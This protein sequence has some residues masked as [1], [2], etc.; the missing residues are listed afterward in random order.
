M[1]RARAR[2]RRGQAP[3][4]ASICGSARWVSI[5]HPLAVGAVSCHRHDTDPTKEALGTAIATTA[6]AAHAA[7]AEFHVFIGSEVDAGGNKN[8]NG[9]GLDIN[10]HDDVLDN[11]NLQEHNQRLSG[12]SGRGCCRSRRAARC[13]TLV[14]Q[15]LYFLLRATNTPH[16]ASRFT[17]HPSHNAFRGCLQ[18]PILKTKTN[19]LRRKSLLSHYVH[20]L[21][22]GRTIAELAIDAACSPSHAFLACLPEIENQNTGRCAPRYQTPKNQGKAL[23]CTQASRFRQVR[24]AVGGAGL[25]S[26]RAGRISSRIVQPERRRYGETVDRN[27]G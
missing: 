19:E 24:E 15:T 25:P 2:R 10:L 9:R 14:Q 23:E 13:T 5:F 16:A 17:R 8:R 21:F 3:T 27:K 4:M 22:A 7:A 18:S 20:L 26:V 12:L 11:R 6:A 1:G